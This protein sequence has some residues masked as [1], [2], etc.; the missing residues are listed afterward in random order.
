MQH[1][2][3]TAL[4]LGVPPLQCVGCSPSD[5]QQPHPLCQD[6]HSRANHLHLRYTDTETL[7]ALEAGPTVAA[8][9][10]SCRQHCRARP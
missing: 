8:T 2:G 1:K 3:I 6:L 4:S 10:S 7:Q 5:S 9:S